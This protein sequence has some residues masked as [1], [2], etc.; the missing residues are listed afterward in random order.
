MRIARRIHDSRSGLVIASTGT[1]IGIAGQVQIG[2]EGAI[3]SISCTLTQIESTVGK[4]FG[5][6]IGIQIVIG[7]FVAM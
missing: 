1:G 5:I 6:D 2:I 3:Y 4:C 7:Y